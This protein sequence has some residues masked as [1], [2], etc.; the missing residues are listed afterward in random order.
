MR[1]LIKSIDKDNIEIVLA[2]DTSLG[3]NEQETSSPIL[4]EN[5]QENKFRLCDNE[6]LVLAYFDPLTDCQWVEDYIRGFFKFEEEIRKRFTSHLI[7][8]Y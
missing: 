3:K 2:I 1:I 8:I 4:S 6:D 5:P 7:F